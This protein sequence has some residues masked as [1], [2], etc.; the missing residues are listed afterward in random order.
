MSYDPDDSDEA[1]N[2]RMFSDEALAWRKEDCR[3]QAAEEA[4]RHEAEKAYFA[5][6]PWPTDPTA[7]N[8]S[9]MGLTELITERGD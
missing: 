7:L 5:S 1:Y 3:R 2:Q 8:G 6:N 9:R 4:A